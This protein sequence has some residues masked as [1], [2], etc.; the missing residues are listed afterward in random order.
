MHSDASTAAG[1]HHISVIVPTWNA[2]RHIPN[3]LAALSRSR[4]HPDKILW[5]DSSSTDQTVELLRQHGQN[6]MSIP[7]A[8]FGHG[9]TRNDALRYC[10]PTDLVVYLTQDAEPQGDDWLAQLIAP[11]DDPAVGVSY[12]RQT[13]RPDA[14]LLERH[15]RHFN[16]PPMSQR[17]RWNDLER[18]GIKAVFCSNSFAAYRVSALKSVGG[19]PEQLPLGEDM[20]AAIRL[21]AQGW[22]R[23]YQAQ[24]VAMHSHNHSLAV[25]FRRYFD[26][27]ALLSMDPALQRAHL[28][29]SGEGLRYV[30]TEWRTAW[31]ARSFHAMGLI[32]MRAAAKFIGFQL[33]RRFRQLPDVWLPHLGLHSNFWRQG[34]K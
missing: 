20:A 15:A 13:P 21:L 3:L 17:S 33:G 7:Q 8:E 18:L 23:V 11:F 30:L 9:R 29:S 28:S 14:H 26:I 4:R 31:Q 10:L 12:G 34:C 24:A 6:V 2:E 1:N 22:D 16:Y 32:P 25:E 19:F 5:I 27:G